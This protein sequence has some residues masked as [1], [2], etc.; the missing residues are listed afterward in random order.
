[1]ED[2]TPKIRLKTV[3]I[4][5]DI[6]NERICLTEKNKDLYKIGITKSLEQKMKQIKPDQIIKT[7][8]TKNY[9]DLKEELHKKHI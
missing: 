5:V 9:A 3:D 2:A 6:S 7:V 4:I 1:M 8:K